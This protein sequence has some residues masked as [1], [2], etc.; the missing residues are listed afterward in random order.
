MALVIKFDE[1]EISILKLVAN[2]KSNE[3]I[4]ESLQLRAN[5]VQKTL[6]SMM[7]ASGTAN[8]PGLVALAFRR[9]IIE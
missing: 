2:G 9:R 4:A 6:R 8:R 7:D 5:Q 1:Q 3:E